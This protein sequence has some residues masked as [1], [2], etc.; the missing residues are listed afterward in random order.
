MHKITEFF[1]KANDRVGFEYFNEIEFRRT[2]QFDKCTPQLFFSEYIYA[3]LNL[4]M[5]EQ[6]MRPIYNKFMQSLD[7]ND[8]TTRFKNKQR[9]AAET[10]KNEFVRW[11]G[12]LKCSKDPVK[13]LESL[14]LIGKTTKYHLAQNLGIEV[15]KPDLHL[16][17]LA[18]ESGFKSPLEMCQQIKSDIGDA[19]PLHVI[20]L[21]LW[22][23]CNLG[24][25]Y[26]SFLL[27]HKEEV[28]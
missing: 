1:L 17:R 2:L 26:E 4:G 21:I 14:P 23:Y 5:R 10:A 11:F 3:I 25:T 16:I 15:V 19:E 7:I 28:Y 27:Q 20:D 6:A 22:R 9:K 12:E 24:Y 18:K 13:Y 8:I